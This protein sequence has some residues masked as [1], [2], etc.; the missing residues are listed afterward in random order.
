MRDELQGPRPPQGRR[1]L[2]YRAVAQLTPGLAMTTSPTVCRA[3][4]VPPPGVHSLI[5]ENPPP[6]PRQTVPVDRSKC[7]LRGRPRVSTENP[8][9]LRGG[10]DKGAFSRPG[11]NHSFP[12]PL[13]LG[14]GQL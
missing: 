4:G 6:P 11:L 13:Q 5:V 14:G 1:C 3:L 9:F 2:W 12:G 10:K 7:W 8:A